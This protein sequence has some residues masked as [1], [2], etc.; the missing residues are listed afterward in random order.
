MLSSSLEINSPGAEEKLM[1]KE[2]E[3]SVQVAG[4][5][6]RIG[7]TITKVRSSRVS[8]MKSTSLH[9]PFIYHTQQ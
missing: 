6:Q 7:E 3:E 4:L 1:E 5:W 8:I 9:I 2:G